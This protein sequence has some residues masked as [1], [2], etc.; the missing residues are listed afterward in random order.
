MRPLTRRLRD[1]IGLYEAI[2]FATGFILMAF[3]LVASR[4]LAPT[5]GTSTYVWTS[6]IGVMIA[7]L[8]AGY[9]VGGWLADKRSEKTD[10]AWLLLGAALA[11]M[12]TDICYDSVLTGI[13]G[14]LSD[15]RAA[16]VAASL[17][18]F[19]PPSFVLGMASPYLARLR[20]Q[21]LHTTGRSVAG[22]S[23]AN[24]VGGIT[25][26][27]C[28]GFIF[29]TIIGSRETLTLLAGVLIACSWFVAPLAVRRQ[30][31][32]VTAA[33]ILMML[34]QFATGA[35]AAGVAEI[36]TPTSHYKITDI[37]WRG[38]PVRT[39]IMGPGGWQSGV[40]LNGSKDLAFDY[41]RKLADVVSAAPYKDSIL[42]LGG[43]AFSLPEYLG[44]HY[45]DAQI[46]VAEIDSKLPGIATQYFGYKQP[47]NVHVYTEDARTYLQRTDKRYDII[48][49]DVYNDS[50][51]PFSM[52]TVEY[53]A[54]LKHALKPQGVVAANIIA[55][56]NTACMPL[57]ASLHT[58]YASAFDRALYY[59][60]EDPT[61]QSE[62]NIIAVYSNTS[63]GWADA[64]PGSSFMQ[65]HGGHTLT[66]NHAPIEYL[67]QK[68]SG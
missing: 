55:A 40:Y 63:L 41:T 68:C 37:T 66:D 2:A 65:L 22:L 15:P 32:L 42:I 38:Q 62:Q 39:L 64:L 17:I 7:A 3:E 49:A 31:L 61:L 23:A 60:L 25:G 53:A 26:T 59:P 45:P 58:T 18:L 57:L 44:Q 21:S 47:P 46:D 27:F 35:S 13:S 67:K 54:S 4:I 34:L 52:T 43:G 28:T 50:S 5:I 48:I 20:V 1:R 9:A 33:L 16:G 30:R 11:I 19:V 51:I 6:V 12:V 56:T 14:L 10:I 29:F 8:A 36:D 24:S